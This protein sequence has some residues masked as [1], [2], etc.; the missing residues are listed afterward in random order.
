[1]YNVWFSK[2]ININTK[3][4]VGKITKFKLLKL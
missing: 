1:M 4:G 2:K 3:Q